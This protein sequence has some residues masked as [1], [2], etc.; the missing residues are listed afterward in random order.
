MLSCRGQARDRHI[1]INRFILPGLDQKCFMPNSDT[2]IGA[3][4]LVKVSPGLEVRVI[5]IAGKVF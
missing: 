3:N 1:V 4:A 2:A 5:G